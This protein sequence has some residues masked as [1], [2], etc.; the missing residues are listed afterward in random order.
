[1]PGDDH[2][3]QGDYLLRLRPERSSVPVVIRLRH[4]LKALLRTYGFRAL[5][6]EEVPADRPP[7]TAADA[8]G[9]TDDR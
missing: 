2:R 5:S 3:R 1:M 7:A 8:A 6:V 4:V 9:G